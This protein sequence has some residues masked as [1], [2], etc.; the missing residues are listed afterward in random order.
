MSPM[1]K[2]NLYPQYTFESFV[3]APSN[4]FVY[5]VAK[6]ICREPGVNYNPVLIYGEEGTGKTHLLHAI[7]NEI[8]RKTLN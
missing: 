5:S 6:S 8:S 4:R 7:G 3:V 2:N 1:R